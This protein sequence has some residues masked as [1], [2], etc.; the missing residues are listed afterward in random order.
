MSAMTPHQAAKRLERMAYTL[1]ALVDPGDRWF[2]ALLLRRV[3]EPGTDLDR[4]LGLRSRTGGRGGY[5]GSPLP[6][7][8]RLLRVLAASL[9]GT[10]QDKA[11]DIAALARRDD[12]S[13]EHIAH[14]ARIPDVRQLQRILS[15]DI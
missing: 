15:D 13:L 8:D 7:R 1:A 5:L 14:L 4:L 3:R 11:R 10:V 2:P 12:P 6:E 9:P